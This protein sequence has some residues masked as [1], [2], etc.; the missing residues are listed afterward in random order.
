MGLDWLHWINV[1]L[2]AINFVLCLVFQAETLYERPQSSYTSDDDVLNKATVD[3]KESV[4]VADSVA[5]S[6]YPSYSYLRSLKLITYQPGIGAKLLAPY[7][8]LRLPGVW[9]ISAWYAGLVGLIVSEDY[10]ERFKQ[11]KIDTTN[12]NV[13]NF[14]NGSSSNCRPTPI[15]LGQGR[16]TDQ[17]WRH[18]WGYPRLCKSFEPQ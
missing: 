17:H 10:I 11:K 1:V 6:A 2:S 18:H 16:W 14:V 4:A 12:S 8:V 3:T 9:L 7:K 5:P 15:S 13:G